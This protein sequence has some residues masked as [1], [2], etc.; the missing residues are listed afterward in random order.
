MIAFEVRRS[1]GLD[2]LLRYGPRMVREA[3]VLTM[4]RG[5]E[6]HIEAIHQHI[7]SG[8]SFTSRTGA[9]ERSIQWR[10]VGDHV[11]VF[12]SAPHA[13]YIELGTGLWGPKHARYPIVPKP[14]RQA[15]RWFSGGHAVF[16]RRVMHPGIRPRPFM[17]RDRPPVATILNAAR[18]AVRRVFGI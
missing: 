3:A 12:A 18:D 1:P 11:E 17:L 14:G 9:L 4:E 15:L 7:R 8:R 13:P 5:A 10:R 6:A 2:R 16:S